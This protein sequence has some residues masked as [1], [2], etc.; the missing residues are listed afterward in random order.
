[1]FP[2]S[3]T[4]IEHQ[5]QELDVEESTIKEIVDILE[6]SEATSSRASSAP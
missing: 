5:L 3:I 4:A 1:M 2:V 6:E